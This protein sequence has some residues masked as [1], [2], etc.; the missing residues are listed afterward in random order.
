MVHV[1]I[2]IK[3]LHSRYLYYNDVQ[4]YAPFEAGFGA[5]EASILE[6]LGCVD[7]ADGY[8]DAGKL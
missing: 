6:G 4:I 2:I 7:A 1:Y 5:T 8:V 3:M